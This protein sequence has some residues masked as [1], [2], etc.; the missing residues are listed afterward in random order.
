VRIHQK[1][2]RRGIVVTLAAAL[3]VPVMGALAPLTAYAAVNCVVGPGVTQTDTVVTGSPG[4]DTIDCGGTNPAKTINGNGGNDTITGSALDDTIDGGDGNDTITGGT[5]L[6][7]FFGGLGD[8]TF[9]SGDAEVDT[10]NGDD[11]QDTVTGDEDDELFDVEAAD[12]GGGGRSQPDRVMPALPSR[13][14]AFT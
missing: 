1:Q 3:A 7:V 12:L 11:G 13:K 9:A 14:V 6:D 10:V 5:G 8:D 2:I 4:N